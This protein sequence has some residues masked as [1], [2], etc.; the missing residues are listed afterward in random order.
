MCREDRA[1]A[2]PYALRR[3]FDNLAS[4][5]E[6]YA[7]AQSPVSLTVESRGEMTLLV[8]ENRKRMQAAAGTESRGIGIKSIRQIAAAYGGEVEIKDTPDSF[9]I[10]ISLNL[11]SD[12]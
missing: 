2:D 5:V 12:L 6:K 7:D 1:A 4:N 8:Q 9:A 11:K 3:I 10:E